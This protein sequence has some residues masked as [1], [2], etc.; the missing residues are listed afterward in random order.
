MLTIIIIILV[1]WSKVQF[2]FFFS[3]SNCSVSIYLLY[4]LLHRSYISLFFFWYIYCYNLCVPACC[5]CMLCD[6]CAPINGIVIT[7]NNKKNL[8]KLEYVCL[9]LFSKLSEFVGNLIDWI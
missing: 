1:W 9:F 7:K 5:L 2:N 8:Y 4:L 6:M 3:V